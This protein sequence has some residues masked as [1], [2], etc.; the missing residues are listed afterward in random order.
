MNRV[1]KL[2]FIIL[3]FIVLHLNC[4]AANLGW[5]LGPGSS[6][7]KGDYLQS[8]NGKYTLIMQTDGSLVI[9]RVA[10]GKVIYSMEKRGEFAVMQTDGNF[11]EYASNGRWLW[12]THTEVS[13]GE[14]RIAYLRDDGSLI[15]S[16]LL[17]LVIAY[18]SSGADPDTSNTAVRYPMTVT[19]LGASPSAPAIPSQSENYYATPELVIKK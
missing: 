14:Q 11:V 13:T 12:A 18:W 10:D 9:Y 3:S 16:C 19:N 5:T 2:F 4:N 8:Q 17:P 1:Y 7:Q 15:I 6:L